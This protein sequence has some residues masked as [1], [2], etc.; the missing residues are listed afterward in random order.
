VSI[1][2]EPFDPLAAADER[3]VREEADRLLATV[4]AG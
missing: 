3:A 2:L 4:F 1:V